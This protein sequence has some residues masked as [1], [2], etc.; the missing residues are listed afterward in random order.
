MFLD[1]DIVKPACMP[2]TQT[3]CNVCTSKSK[4]S[5]S[6]IDQSVDSRTVSTIYYLTIQQL[7]YNLKNKQPSHSNATIINCPLHEGLEARYTG[8]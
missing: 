5:S 6:Q 7:H 8:L 2:V 3:L 1:Y 4:L